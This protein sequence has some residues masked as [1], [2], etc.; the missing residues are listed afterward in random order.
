MPEGIGA[1]KF[2]RKPQGVFLFQGIAA[3]LHSL[4]TDCPERVIIPEFLWHLVSLE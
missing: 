3:I 4:A 2:L 1:I